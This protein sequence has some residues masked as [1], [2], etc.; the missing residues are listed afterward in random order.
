MSLDTNILIYNHYSE[1][2]NKRGI[3]NDLL[4]LRPVIATQVVSEYLNVMKRSFPITKAELTDLCLR[5]MKKCIIHPVDVST[6]EIARRLI[7][8]Y[9]FQLFD[10]L[11]VAAAIE[12][13]CEALY[14]E[15]MQHGMLVEKQLRIINPFRGA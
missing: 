10:A 5:W 2:E 7:R 13:G 15:D 14:S 12:A 8:R 11:I 3:T 9:D 1:D 4:S 6:V